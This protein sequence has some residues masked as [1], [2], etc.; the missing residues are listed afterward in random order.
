MLTSLPQEVIFE[1]FLFC[2]IESLLNLS[3]TCDT[4]K[5]ILETEHFCRNY[6]KRLK[7][8]VEPTKQSPT[9][10][11]IVNSNYNISLMIDYDFDL[12]LIEKIPDIKNY[13]EKMI[14]SLSL[15]AVRNNS[16]NCL[17]LLIQQTRFHDIY[18][19]L[20]QTS[21]IYD[22]LD[23]FQY[24]TSLI[25]FVPT[26]YMLESIKCSTDH[27]IFIWLLD[28]FF[29]KQMKNMKPI[30]GIAINRDNDKVLKI[31]VEKGNSIFDYLFDYFHFTFYNFGHK[32]FKFL[33]C[34]PNF[35]FNFEWGKEDGRNIYHILFYHYPTLIPDVIPIFQA[36][37]HLNIN[38]V[39]FKG[40]RPIDCFMIKLRENQKLVPILGYLLKI[41]SIDFSNIQVPS[42]DEILPILPQLQQ[43]GWTPSFKDLNDSIRNQKVHLFK[44]LFDHLLTKFYLNSQ[45]QIIPLS[46]KLESC[47]YQDCF[48]YV[49]KKIQEKVPWNVYFVDNFLTWLRWG[50]SLPYIEPTKEFLTCAEQQYQINSSL[51]VQIVLTMIRVNFTSVFSVIDKSFFEAGMFRPIV[52]SLLS[53]VRPRALLTLC[54]LTGTTISEL[55]NNEENKTKLN[56]FVDALV[57]KWSGGKRKRCSSS[58]V[59]FK[60]LWSTFETLVKDND[61]K[62]IAIF[63][64]QHPEIFNK[65]RLSFV[66]F[67]H[68]KQLAEELFNLDTIDSNETTQTTETTETNVA[69]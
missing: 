44:F 53:E 46:L 17:K 39:D 59:G 48:V 32:V 25:N 24:L 2:D 41:D 22:Q 60:Q 56:F 68:F 14:E 58:D 49:F 42:F 18:P 63:I 23:I 11:Q 54:K 66:G 64:R 1:L 37:S 8:L 13:S 34:H 30:V 36:R 57:L 26:D 55:V 5:D 52:K 38:L 67:R 51:K 40:K 20:I 4:F 50:N 47:L 29:S 62:Q 6:S 3:L 21:I 9:F 27:K 69:T 61:V 35:D 19:N 31:L 10:Q 65:Q 33:V 28:N 7:S 15:G 45:Q 43:K 16:L 12:A